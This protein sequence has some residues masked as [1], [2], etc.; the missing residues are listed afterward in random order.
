M[1]LYMPIQITVRSAAGMGL[2]VIETIE[3]LR[4]EPLHDRDNPDNE[5]HSYR[6][7]ILET[8]QEAQFKHRYGDGAR[9]CVMNALVA[10]EFGGGETR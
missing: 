6:V 4:L 2:N 7:K 1:G 10:L 8:G 5:I 9:R 3:I